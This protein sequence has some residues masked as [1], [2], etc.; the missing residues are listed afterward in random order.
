MSVF[1]PEQQKI[2]EGPNFVNVATLGKDGTPRSTAIWVDLDGD[3]ILLNGTV[4]RK[5]LLNLKRNPAIALSIYGTNEPYKQVNV[6][7]EAV[8]FTR[9]GGY[10]HIEKLS[11]KYTGGPYKNHNPNDPREIVRVKVK[12]VRGNY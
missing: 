7:G 4:S 2:F 8:E 10:E 9:E 1:K 5:W 12:K 11:R 6:L 3:D